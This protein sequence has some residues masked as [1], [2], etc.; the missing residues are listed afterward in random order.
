MLENDY[1]QV[2]LFSISAFVDA[3]SA[4]NAAAA[5]LNNAADEIWRQGLRDKLRSAPRNKLKKRKNRK[6]AARL[7][8]L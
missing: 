4:V 2:S 7:A 5:I 3:I 1:I 8:P 6:Q